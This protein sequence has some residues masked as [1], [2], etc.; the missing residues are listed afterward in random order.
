MDIN[1]WGYINPKLPK[2]QQNSRLALSCNVR[3]DSSCEMIR[4]V[5]R[6]WL[7]DFPKMIRVVCSLALLS[8]LGP[9]LVQ[10]RV[11]N[12]SEGPPRHITAGHRYWA[13]GLGAEHYKPMAVHRS[14]RWPNPRRSQR[15]KKLSPRSWTRMTNMMRHRKLSATCGKKTGCKY[16]KKADASGGGV[17][18]WG[19][20][21]ETKLSCWGTTNLAW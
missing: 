21:D 9:C 15:I 7:N 2:Q 13:N 6:G 3:I 16:A 5:A 19:C 14:Q 12:R 1:K 11:P 17:D 8:L 4:D 10:G 20:Y 18:A